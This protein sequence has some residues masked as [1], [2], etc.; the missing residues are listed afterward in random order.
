M[1][2]QALLAHSAP[3]SV[4]VRSICALFNHLTDRAAFYRMVTACQ[5]QLRRELVHRLGILNV[6]SPSYPGALNIFAY[7]FKFSVYFFYSCC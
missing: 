5:D 2:L 7:V 4:I 6:W 1:I 3:V